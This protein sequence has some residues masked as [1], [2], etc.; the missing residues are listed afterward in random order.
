MSYGIEVSFISLMNIYLQVCVPPPGT[1]PWP[2]GLEAAEGADQPGARGALRQVAV[3]HVATA[4]SRQAKIS[5][6]H[7]FLQ[8]LSMPKNVAV[9]YRA[10]LESFG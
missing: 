5:E 9:A 8:H 3:A 7:R 10:G 1:V 6:L 4:G 2:A